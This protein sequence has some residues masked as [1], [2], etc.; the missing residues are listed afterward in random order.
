MLEQLVNLQSD[1]WLDLLLDD[2]AREGELEEDYVVK[3]CP[4]LEKLYTW[5]PIDSERL[6]YLVQFRKYG[7]SPLKEVRL[8]S[9]YPG[10]GVVDKE[11]ELWL[12]EN[13]DTFGFFKRA[14]DYLNE[15]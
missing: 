1:K 9:R 12:K 14:E 2:T 6:K 15:P 11:H 8:C 13:L 10:R 4:N 5:G 7:G 3:Y